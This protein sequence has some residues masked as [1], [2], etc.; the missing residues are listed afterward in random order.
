MGYSDVKK[1]IVDFVMK[2]GHIIELMPNRSNEKQNYKELEILD[3]YK[4]LAI[5]FPGYKTTNEKCDYC[6]YLVDGS[7]EK[8]IS[9]VEIMQDLYNKVTKDNF[10]HLKQYVEDVA[11]IG[12]DVKKE[13]YGNIDFD[14]GFTFQELTGLMFYI[15]I[16]EDIN[17]PGVRYQG[18]KMCFYRYLEAIYCKNNNNH[19]INEAFQRANARGYIP[20]NWGDVGKLYDNIKQIQR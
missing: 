5:R 2:D 10:N 4:K 13:S 8:P 7:V 19:T 17:Y 12:K 6:V 14:K 18:R 16:Q 9:H 15:A 3:S 20:N 11:R 1:K